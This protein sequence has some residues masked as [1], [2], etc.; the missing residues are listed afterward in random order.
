M[1]RGTEN[2]LV[3]PCIGISTLGFF[4]RQFPAGL[5][6]SLPVLFLLFSLGGY[7][8]C[9]AAS[10]GAVDAVYTFSATDLF[11]D[12]FRPYVYASSGASLQVINSSTLAVERSIQLPSAAHGMTMSPDGN[13]LY[14]AGGS[15]QSI[16]VLDPNNW[17]LLPSLS[18]GDSPSDL[19]MGLSN[20]LFVLGNSLS[21]IDA[22]TGASTGPDAPVYP[23]SGALRISPDRT[24]LYYAD[25]G[26]SPGT[27]YK[28]DVSSTNPAILWQNGTDIGE[29]GEQLALSLDGSMVAYVCGYGYEGYQIPNFRTSD[30]SLAGVF[31]T[32]AYPDCLAYSPDG[33][34][35]YALHT[36][37]PTAVDIYDTSSYERVGQFAVVDQA[38]VMTADQTGQHLFIAFNGVYDGHTEVRAYDT[39][40]TTVSNQP[41][42]SSPGG[43]YTAE[44]QGAATVFQLDGSAS[45]DPQG[46][47][48]AYTWRSDCSG[49]SFDN[50]TSSTPKLTMDA[51]AA[52]TCT[53]TL[54]VSDGQ[55]TNSAQAVVMVVDTTSPTID[56]PTNKVVELGSGWNFDTPTALDAC[57]GTNITITVSD[58]VTNASTNGCCSVDITR[59]WQAIDCSG[60]S[61][62]CSQTVT[63]VNTRPPDLSHL[64]ACPTILWPPNHKL[65]P[66]VIEG[67]VTDVC[68]SVLNC[69]IVSVTDN[70]RNERRPDL[71]EPDYLIT[72]ARTVL[73]RAERDNTYSSRIYWILMEA[74]DPCGNTVSRKIEVVVP[75]SR[76]EE[77]PR[78]R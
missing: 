78:D 27:L 70:E 39:G 18:V 10:A 24:T 68:G 6:T 29:N 73:L 56:C 1:F 76:H 55:L 44:C 16:M 36:L 65:V 47:P 60:N 12:P 28:L 14:I 46:K 58:T 9:L 71:R 57:C 19:A 50:P 31:P 11:V 52:Q 15:S 25:F 67:V 77:R 42:V 75:G 7:K 61:N 41:P 40:L 23:Y 48:L 13:K 8:T 69:R 37:Y 21:Q 32:G 54:V 35:A 38:K 5:V 26:L 43:P 45:S 2:Q 17:N 34:Y 51:T 53:V 30:M 33:K 62:A 72:G 3:R 59:T 4:Q 74:E 66:V 22:T 20:R 63:V 64:R 49:A